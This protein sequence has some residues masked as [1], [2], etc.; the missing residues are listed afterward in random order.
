VGS[1]EGKSSQIVGKGKP[2]AIAVFYTLPHCSVGKSRTTR[3]GLTVAEMVIPRVTLLFSPA[4]SHRTSSL[5]FLVTKMSMGKVFLG[6][7]YFPLVAL[8]GVRRKSP[9]NNNKTINRNLLQ[10]LTLSYLVKK[11]SS[12][13][14]TRRVSRSQQ[15]DM[16]PFDTI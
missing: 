6:E 8:S 16:E 3:Y 7:L 11:Y 10:E 13:H 4:I 1:R 5:R 12:L 2:L 15:T 9:K 14:Y